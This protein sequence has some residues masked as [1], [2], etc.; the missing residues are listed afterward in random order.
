M[1]AKTTGSRE[2]MKWNLGF[3]WGALKNNSGNES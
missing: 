1:T 2:M 3:I